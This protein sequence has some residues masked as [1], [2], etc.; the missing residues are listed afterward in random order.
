MGENNNDL[1]R[2]AEKEF[3][4]DTYCEKGHLLN[5]IHVSIWVIVGWLAVMIPIYWTV[6]ATLLRHRITPV[7]RYSEGI[8]MYF[9]MNWLF[10]LTAVAITIIAAALT[11]RNNYK[12]KKYLKKEILYDQEKVVKRSHIYDDLMTERF[13]TAEK[14]ENMRYYEVPGDKNLDTSEIRDAYDKEG[15][16]V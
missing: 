5:K 16:G 13:G 1:R 10:L 2:E 9:K 12:T 15:V 6:S 8:T 14:R 3:V 7:W 4:T 11:V